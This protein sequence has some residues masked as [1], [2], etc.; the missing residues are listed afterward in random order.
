MSQTA[1]E[2]NNTDVVISVRHVKKQYETAGSGYW[3]LKGVNLQVLRGEFIAIVGKSGSGKSTLLNLLGGIDKQ[4][5]GSVVINGKALDNMSENRLSRFRG[6]NIGFIFQ[7]FQLMP[8]LTCLENVMLPMEFLKKI[9]VAERRQRA[10][11]LLKKVGI[12]DQANKFPAALSGGEQQRVAIARALAN[13][14][15]II[16]ADEPTGNLDSQTSEDIFC[17]MQALA[18]EGKSV[19]MVTHND[20]LAARCDRI[21]RI[22]DGEIVSDSKRVE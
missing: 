2:H 11:E 12:F 13:D 6:Q 1:Q 7:F 5:E 17:M 10:N 16:F 8:T 3:A 22:R 14:P 21:V 15:A 9:T 18:R 4:S 20:D 19:V